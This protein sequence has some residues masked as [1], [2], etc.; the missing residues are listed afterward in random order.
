M[1]TAMTPELLALVAGRFRAL[2]DPVRLA[3]LNALREGE[4]SVGD[5]VDVVGLSQANVSKHLAHL[6]DRGFIRRRKD[7]PFVYYAL[8]DTRIFALCDLVCGQ[9]DEEL[10]D[11]A[12]V[13]RA[14]SIPAA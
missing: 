3:L 10:D 2:S 4:R 1:K 14:A 13:V 6:H 8:A 9:L 5:L 7:G 11:R 12:R